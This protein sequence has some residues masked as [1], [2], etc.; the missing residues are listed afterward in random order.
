MKKIDKVILALECHY[1]RANED[2]LNVCPY[3]GEGN[4]V[5]PLMR[6][7]LEVL[8]TLRDDL[9]G[10]HDETHRLMKSLKVVRAERDAA[11]EKL[12]W[13]AGS[14][15]AEWLSENGEKVPDFPREGM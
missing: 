5:E 8:Q 15:E 11:R 3:D 6:D 4:C 10:A 2:C 1:E 7:C 13:I 12:A 14:R 9:Q